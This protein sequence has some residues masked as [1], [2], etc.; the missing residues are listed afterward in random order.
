MK[1]ELKT[2]DKN[3]GEELRSYIEKLLSFYLYAKTDMIGNR[4]C[5]K[6]IVFDIA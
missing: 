4:E 5:L 6:K 2:S 1:Q 3:N